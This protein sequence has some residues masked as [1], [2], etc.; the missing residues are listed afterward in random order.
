MV[1]TAAPLIV[2]DIPLSHYIHLIDSG[3]HFA[4][5]RYGDGEV[6]CIFGHEGGNCDGHEYFHS[7]GLDLLGTLIPEHQYKLPY[8]YGLVRVASDRMPEEVAAI[9]E[10][11]RVPWVNGTILTSASRQ[12]KLAP[13]VQAIKQKRR[14]VYVGPHH[15]ESF[16]WK[17]LGFAHDGRQAYSQF[18]TIPDKNCYTQIDAIETE[19]R[20]AIIGYRPELVLFSAGMVSNVL[21]HRL[22]QDYQGET[23]LMDVGSLFDGFVGVYSRKYMRQKEWQ[24]NRE[25]NLYGRDQ[26]TQ[27]GSAK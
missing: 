20:A 4:L 14:V 10:S 19:V 11:W 23:T 2:E 6:A 17:R 1:Q 21:I 7:L 25:V 12:Y 9:N 26:H 15:L 18:I 5:S 24:Q 16:F 22:W 8:F 27:A 13:F 3:H